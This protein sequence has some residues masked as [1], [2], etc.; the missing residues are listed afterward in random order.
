MTQP[1][2]S[3]LPAIKNRNDERRQQNHPDPYKQGARGTLHRSHGRLSVVH[4]AASGK[5]AARCPRTAAQ[6]FEAKK[7]SSDPV[8]IRTEESD[9]CTNIQPYRQ[10]QSRTPR[11]TRGEVY[12]ALK[13]KHVEHFEDN[14]DNDNDSDD[15]ED[16]SIHGSW[17]TRRYPPGEQYCC[18]FA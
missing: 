6:L 9:S 17:I 4:S 15:V 1:G 2:R 11:F 12:L 3:W 5:C 18:R 14:N 7:V 10:H 16:I 8:A 13:L